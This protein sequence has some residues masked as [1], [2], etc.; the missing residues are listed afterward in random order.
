MINLVIPTDFSPA[1]RTALHYGVSLAAKLNA[2]VHLLHMI[3][4]ESFTHAAAQVHMNMIL[5]KMTENAQRDLKLL[6]EELKQTHKEVKVKTACLQGEFLAPTIGSFVKENE[7]DLVVMGTRGASGIIGNILGSNAAD[8]ISKS[9][10]PV[11]AVPPGTTYGKHPRIIL[12]TDLNNL[13]PKLRII[14]PLAA[15]LGSGITLLHISTDG[16]HTEKEEEDIRARFSSEFNIKDLKVKIISNESVEN[17]IHDFAVEHQPCILAMFT[18]KSGFFD[19]LFGKSVTR[20]VVFHTE[21]PLLA[22]KH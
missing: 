8:V 11:L 12:T 3:H 18:H 14:A 13:E 1:A 4:V 6:A 10:I 5:E 2:S 9:A 16:I 15:V 20:K 17:G 22:L 19:K 7:I 21:V